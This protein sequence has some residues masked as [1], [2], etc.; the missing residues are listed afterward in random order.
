M[1]QFVPLKHLMLT[2]MANGMINVLKIYKPT[3]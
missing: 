1:L 3:I 2:R